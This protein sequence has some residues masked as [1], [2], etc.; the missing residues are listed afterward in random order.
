MEK[1]IKQKN[2]KKKSDVKKVS[3]YNNYKKEHSS[4]EV[5]LTQYYGFLSDVFKKFSEE[6]VLSNMELRLLKLGKFRV[7][8]VSKGILKK[9]GEMRARKPD[10]ARTKQYWSEK[11]PGL[12]PLELKEINNK[13]II[14]HENEHT[15][16]EYCKHL[17]DKMTV[18]SNN[19]RLY[20]FIPSRQFSRLLASVL[21]DPNRKVFYYA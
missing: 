19:V 18:F 7:Q 16:G 3:F 17:W 14:Y 2:P 6:I 13:L 15:N 21:K 9:N 12:T 20:K 1:T 8:S 4:P 11:Y 10:W 5:S